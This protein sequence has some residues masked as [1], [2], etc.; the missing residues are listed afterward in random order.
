V[1]RRIAPAALVAIVLVVLLTIDI[2][3]PTGAGST[4]A[5]RL[6]YVTATASSAP[7]V[8]LAGVRGGGARPIGPGQNP[9][10]APDGD[11][12]AASS[13]A[14]S[15]PA[16]T[17]Y[18]AGGRALRRLFDA[19]QATALA[20][21]WSPDSRYLAVVLA[22]RD[23]ASAAASGLAVID[24]TT[25]RAALVARG[26]IYGASF[27]PD[28]S[29]RIVYGAAGSPAL[30]ARVDIYVAGAGGS[31]PQ[32]ITH[33]GRS[34][35][36]VWGTTGLAFDRERLRRAAAPDYQIWTMN[37]DGSHP[38]Q[39]THVPVP[40][41]IDGLIPV[42]APAADGGWLLAEY[43]GLDT[44]EAW[45]IALRTRQVRRLE[46]GGAPVT[47][48]ALSRSGATALVDRGGFLEPPSKGTV[49]ALPLTGSAPTRLVAHG[50]EPS[51]NQ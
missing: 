50:A 41:L 31:A 19:A 5:P 48:A 42:A 28:G 1:R 7:Q 51:W 25:L 3:V 22:S 18:S 47:A 39:V 30:D 14:E 23:P 9:L 32:Q 2:D 35:Y 40:P 17:V 8:W 16:L 26:A 20:Q 11:V 21:A 44:S 29:D 46:I 33:D 36:P 12:L 49:E 27:A 15:G 34:L 24:L 4:R 37:P 13:A 43:E 38:V 6:A 10:L 45:A